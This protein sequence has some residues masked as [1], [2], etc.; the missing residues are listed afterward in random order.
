MYFAKN[1]AVKK[2]F[3]EL[4]SE[5]MIHKYYLAEVYGDIRAF[6]KKG[7][8]LIDYPIMHHK[9]SSDR[10][11]AIKTS[12]DE[13]KGKG[14][15]HCL[16]TKIVDFVFLETTNTSVLLI[17]IQKGIRHQI[18]L[19][20]SSIGYPICGDLLYCKASHQEQKLQLFSIG[21]KVDEI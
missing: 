14:R 13:K 3:K 17:E 4:Q 12:N 19:H 10:M 2:K 21:V 8:N 9:F 7:K 20:L 15:K 5:F 18:R 11:V 6:L 1:P 16:V